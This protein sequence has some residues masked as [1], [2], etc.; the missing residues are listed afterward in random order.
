MLI[1][2]SPFLPES[3]RFLMHMGRLNEA[4][5]ILERFGAVKQI[6]PTSEEDSGDRHTPIPPVEPRYAGSTIALTLAALAWGMVNFGVLLWLPSAL[7]AEG[8]SVGASSKIVAQ[9]ALL[10]APVVLACVW[11]YGWW[12]SKWSLVAMIGTM[13]AGLVALL[14]RGLGFSLLSNPLVPVIAILLPYTAE[15]YPIRIR[16]RATGWIAGCSKLG[17]LMAQILS[18]LA[19]VPAF[20]AAALAVAVPAGTSLVLIAI[21]GRETRGRDLRELERKSSVDRVSL[22]RS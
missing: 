15:N 14:L 16:G 13:T 19:L 7:V 22:S 21:L 2:L 20:G 18:V 9:S 8:N 10:S 11:S 5:A 4:R 17:G 1:A 3:A 12:S 6:P